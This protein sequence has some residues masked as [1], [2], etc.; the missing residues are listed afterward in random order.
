MHI[1]NLLLFLLR[2][3]SSLL[4]FFSFALINYIIARSGDKSTKNNNL[5][6][7][8]FFYLFFTVLLCVL[9]GKHNMNETEREK[10]KHYQ[11]FNMYSVCLC[12]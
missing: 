12:M 10:K 6:L 8:A 1:A 3:C 4:L 5:H 9:R 2:L 7:L 11:K